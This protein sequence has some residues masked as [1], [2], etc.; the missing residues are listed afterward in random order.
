MSYNLNGRIIQNHRHINPYRNKTAIYE[1]LKLFLANK[2]NFIKKN[3]PTNFL[4]FILFFNIKET[5]N[6]LLTN[7][8]DIIKKL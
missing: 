5:Y 2:F 8:N 3:D 6:I 1:P 7:E 4:E